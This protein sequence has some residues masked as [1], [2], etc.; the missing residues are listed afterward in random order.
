[1]NHPEFLKWNHY[2]GRI[3]EGLTRRRKAERHLLLYGEIKE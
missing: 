1:L 2:G 3:L